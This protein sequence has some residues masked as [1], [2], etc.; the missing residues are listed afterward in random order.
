MRPQASPP[1][2]GST[3]SSHGLKGVSPLAGGKCFAVRAK[4]NVARELLENASLRVLEA[5]EH[6]GACHASGQAEQHAV[7][8]AAAHHTEVQTLS[9]LE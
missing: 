7:E 5:S 9:L 6:R 3:S 2:A 8:Q 1:S 4:R